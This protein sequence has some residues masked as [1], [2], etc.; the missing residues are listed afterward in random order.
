MSTQQPTPPPRLSD[1]QKRQFLKDGFIIIRNAVPR[2]I[3]QRAKEVILPDPGKGVTNYRTE[4]KSDAEKAMRGGAKTNVARHEAV[5]ALFND[6]V[7]APLLRTEMG[8]FS[9]LYSSQVAVTPGNTKV[10]FAGEENNPTAKLTAHV[11]GSF[12][13]NLKQPLSEVIAELERGPPGRSLHRYFKDAGDPKSLGQGG[14]P[15][16]QDPGKTLSIGSYTALVGVALNDQTTPG[17]GQFAVR[18]GAHEAVEA[19]FRMQR[20]NGG[21][22]GPEGPG[23]PRITAGA[24]GRAQA[25]AM[26]ERLWRSY[27]EAK[28]DI[29]GWPYPDLT[30]VLLNEGDAVIT[31]HSLPH[32]ATPNLSEDPRMN[33]YFRLRRKREGNPFEGDK[34]VAHGLSDHPDRGFFGQLLE[35]D[36]EKYD[37]WKTSI[38]KLCDH[39]SEWDGMR[40]LAAEERQQR[41]QGDRAPQAGGEAGAGATARSRL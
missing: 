34:R 22:V 1:A 21:P 9:P 12:S 11:D 10:L 37:P 30:P 14:A 3:T 38:A 33:V 29:Q 35:Y 6:S 36:L 40:D 18:R 4:A 7:L 25:G 31:L 41:L 26:P 16:W 24:K 20:D 23:W 8:P 2:E 13:D 15:L 39:W 17:K 5:L 32:T 19:F 27:P 28:V